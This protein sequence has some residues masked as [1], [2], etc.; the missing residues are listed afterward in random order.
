VSEAQ[1]S[2][3]RV[4]KEQEL[5]IRTTLLTVSD[6]ASQGVYED[7]SGRL[8]Q[9]LLTKAGIEVLAT[10]IV[11]DDLEQIQVE[12]IRLA[13]NFQP[14]LLLTTGG[15]GFSPRDLTPEATR[16]VVAREVPGIPEMLRQHSAQGDKRTYLSRATAGI[17]GKTLI[18]NLPGSTR[19]VQEQ[20]DT[21]VTILPHAVAMVRGLW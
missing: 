8:L 4:D 12:L 9:E 14:D 3:F 16:A 6:R 21:L 7:K 15:T 17:R 10:S 1:S 11:P 18:V 5:N 20:W 19:A 2:H 13:D